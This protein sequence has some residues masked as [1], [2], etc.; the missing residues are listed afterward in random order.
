MGWRRSAARVVS[1]IALRGR[2]QVWSMWHLFPSKMQSNWVF[3]MDHVYFVLNVLSAIAAMICLPLTITQSLTWKSW[4]RSR[5]SSK[6]EKFNERIQ[7]RIDLITRLSASSRRAQ[8]YFFSKLF[9]IL[10]LFLVA[11]LYSVLLPFSP[12]KPVAIVE[13]LVIWAAAIL[14]FIEPAEIAFQLVDPETAIKR[15]EQRKK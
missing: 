8:A 4:R 1:S 14:S 3:L 5:R 11:F 13:F 9:L 7:D 12:S 6:K 2:R 15:M 10:L